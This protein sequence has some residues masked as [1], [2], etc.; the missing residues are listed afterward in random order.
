MKKKKIDFDQ[1]DFEEMLFN[2]A[3]TIYMEDYDTNEI[4]KIF[5]DLANNRDKDILMSNIINIFK[6]KVTTNRSEE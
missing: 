3:S 4:E 1:G 5:I 6:K 2:L